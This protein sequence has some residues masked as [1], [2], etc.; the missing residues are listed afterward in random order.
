MIINLKFKI[1]KNLKDTITTWLAII[2][3][4]VGAVNTYLQSQ[5]GDINWIQLIMFVV[6]AV[7]AYLTGKAPNGTTKTTAQ[8]DAGN[9]K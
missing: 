7:I 6:G 9:A 8:I 4:V 2:M 3:V 5:T 1:M